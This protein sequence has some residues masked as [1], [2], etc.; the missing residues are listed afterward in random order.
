MAK[1]NELGEWG[2]KMAMLHLVKLGYAIVSQNEKIGCYEIDIIATKGD[3]I[4]FVEVKTR[5]KSYEDPVDAVDEKRMR[6]MA[7]AAD[8]YIRAYNIKFEPQFDV[9]TIVGTPQSGYE[10]VHFPDAFFP[11]LETG[12]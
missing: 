3:T 4:A 8:S 5:E 11:P 2:E 1:H 7:R 12:R 6:R 9:I 10:L